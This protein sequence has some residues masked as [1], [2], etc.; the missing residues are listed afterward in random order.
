MDETAGGSQQVIRNYDELL[1]ALKARRK[2]LGISQLEMDDRCG[3]PQGYCGK[4]ESTPGTGRNRGNFRALGPLSMGE[5]L[6]ALGLGLVVES[7][8]KAVK[9]HRTHDHQSLAA[10]QTQSVESKSAR[11]REI[12]L[13]RWKR[14]GR[15]KRRKA[16]SHAAR[17]RWRK[18]KA[19]ATTP[20]VL[21]A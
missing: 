17:A 9:S 13:R 7:V 1:S 19:S 6:T 10:P 20:G 14:V 11:M 16:A 18:A 2:A 5:L 21:S 12:A 15:S 8:N 3:W 4:L